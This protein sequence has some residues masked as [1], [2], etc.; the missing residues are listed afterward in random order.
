MGS[1]SLSWLLLG[2]S[3]L[4]LMQTPDS[5]QIVDLMPAHRAVAQSALGREDARC[6]RIESGASCDANPVLSGCPAGLPYP[7]N[8]NAGVPGAFCEV[9]DTPP[10][11]HD[12]CEIV[13]NDPVP[14]PTCS[15]VAT[16]CYTVYEGVCD[17]DAGPWSW[18]GFCWTC[19][20]LLPADPTPKIRGSRNVCAAG[21]TSC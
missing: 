17:H 7:C 15:T 11:K 19:G 21:S 18:G 5:G 16:Y 6:C 3:V 13:P 2:V 14:P 10:K 9:M 12:V 4:G 20:C 1:T 8:C